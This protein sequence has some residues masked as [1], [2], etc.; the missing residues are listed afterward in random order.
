M[1]DR[2]LEGVEAEQSC[3]RAVSLWED[4]GGA[5][6]DGP[7]GRWS[8][9]ATQPEVPPLADAELIQLRVRVIALENLMIT[10][11][12]QES[13]RQLDLARQ[14]AAYICPRPGFTPH[15][16][17]IR[18]ASQMIHL[19]ERAS[20]FRDAMGCCGPGPLWAQ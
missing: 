20:G 1:A 17:T 12:A 19:L 15:P 2:K 3:L 11:L 18:A 10:L 4:E 5:G 6:P 8:F 13:G 14:M 9:S 7:Y 16:L